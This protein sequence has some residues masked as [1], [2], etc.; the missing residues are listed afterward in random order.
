MNK[1]LPLKSLHQL[2]VV[3]HVSFGSGI[4]GA[5]TSKMAKYYHIR[6][7]PNNIITWT[8]YHI[9][10]AEYQKHHKAICPR[11]EIPWKQ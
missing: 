11:S 3:E 9:S 4:A 1:Q 10:N 7:M 2:L 5:L 8:V 6:S